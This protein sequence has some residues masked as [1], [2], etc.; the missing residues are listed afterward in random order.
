M[1]NFLFKISYFIFPILILFFGIEIYF[2]NTPNAFIEKAN[3]FNK[4]IDKIEVLILGT[5]HSQNGINPAYI[6]IPASNLANGSQDIKI[7]SALFFSEAKK[8]KKLKT[9]ILELDY[10]RM[11]IE[12]SKDF[13]RLPW[14]YIYYKV[15]IY[16][17]KWINKISLYSSNTTF[18]NNNLLQRF[19]KEY[20]EQEINQFGF[21]EKNYESEFQNK[22]YDSIQ[23]V[24]TAKQRLKNRH[25]EVSPL[26]FEKNKKRVETIIEYCLNNNIKIII[27]S[28]PLYT[29][30]I[31][32]QNSNK[33][34]KVS[35]FIE[36]LQ[37]KYA[38]EYYNFEK[39]KTFTIKDFKD[40]DHLT[41]N[42]AKKYSSMINKIVTNK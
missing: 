7:D 12:N 27:V 10:H 5:S 19:K 33:K 28:S 9:V 35:T 4:N 32:N 6:E 1:K 2:R 8:M 26:Q 24:N 25:K 30:Y 23:I 15:E 37:K 13:Y 34:K 3:H 42:G 21:V 38:I 36:Q 29:T 14:Y 16:P 18:F 20:K 40:D 22:N 11:D 41:P 39:N 31:S 17:I